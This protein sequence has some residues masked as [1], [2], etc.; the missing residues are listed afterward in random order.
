MAVTIENF[1]ARLGFKVDPQGAKEFKEELKQVAGT[2]AKLTGAAYALGAGIIAGISHV[3]EETLQMKALAESIGMNVISFKNLK[4]VFASVGQDEMKMV[5]MLEKLNAVMGGYDEDA[6]ATKGLPASLKR[7]N[8]EY[9][10]LKKK[11]PEEQFVAIMDAAKSMAD[12]QVAANAATAIFGRGTGRFL[13]AIRGMEGGIAEIIEKRQALNFLT[14][15]GVR[16]AADEAK[17]LK[18]LKGVLSSINAEMSGLI[19]EA[20]APYIKKVMEWIKANKELIQTEVA[21]WA[22]R[23]GSVM[24]LMLDVLREFIDVVASIRAALNN[25]NPALRKLFDLFVLLAGAK[26]FLKMASM[27]PILGKLIPLVGKLGMS[28]KS[29]AGLKSMGL[30]ALIGLFILFMNSLRR[31]FQ[32]KQ[33]FVGD[34]GAEVGKILYEKIELA[35]AKLD[36]FF[37]WIKIK[38]LAMISDIQF[39]VRELFPGL[40]D[41]I[42]IPETVTGSNGVKSKSGSRSLTSSGGVVGKIGMELTGAKKED[43]DRAQ[44]L[45]PTLRRLLTGPDEPAAPK[46][47]LIQTLMKLLTS[48]TDASAA[49]KQVGPQSKNEAKPSMTFDVKMNIN[50]TPGMD[51]KTLAAN[52]S[53]ALRKEAEALMRYG[54]T[55]VVV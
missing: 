49:P 13:G 11:K 25:L 5:A 41:M 6:N 14:E 52:V 24:K 53:Q 34:F 46:Q 26:I 27:I 38:W 39:N 29:F 42:G 7:L 48:S 51:E 36:E 28:F 37:G 30:F 54:V 40:A 23:I 1:I 16:G 10:E 20:I 21:K 35:K 44:Q 2:M 9:D 47:D 15:R 3:N 8:L 22:E 33:S 19:G 18:Q 4:G 17:A 12:Q 32:G 50:A 31:Y 45:I 43:W 55:G